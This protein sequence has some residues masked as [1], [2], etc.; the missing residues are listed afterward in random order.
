MPCLGQ[1]GIP[2][3][4]QSAGSERDSL[5]SLKGIPFY[6]EERSV[7]TLIPQGRHEVFDWSRIGLQG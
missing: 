3:Y 1:K 4:Q 5:L 6:A 2:N 7:F